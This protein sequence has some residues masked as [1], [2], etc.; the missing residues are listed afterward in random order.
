MRRRELI[1]FF[2]Q[3]AA[4][5]PLAARSQSRDGPPIIGFLAPD[6]VSWSS[7]IAAFESELNKLGWIEGR[8]VAIEYRWSQGNPERIAEVAAEFVREKVDVIVTYGSAVATLKRATTSIPIV[9][10]VASDPLSSGII[11]NLAHPGGNVTGFSAQNEIA[12]KRLELFRELVP[13][14]RRFAILFDPDYRANVVENDVVQAAAS[15]LGLD[16]TAYGI[17]RKE[18]IAPV[19]EVL[20][21][22]TDAIYF[23]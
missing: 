21:G 9:F 22:V 16:G 12:G 5:W 2:S 17:R 19:F 15:K 23:V 1:V 8:T 10:A 13:N 18:D 3:A 14:M 7:W 11:T 4:F 20:E 6:K